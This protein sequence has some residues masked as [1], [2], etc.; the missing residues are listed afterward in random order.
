MSQAGFVEHIGDSAADIHQNQANSAPNRSVRAHARAEAVDA[1]IDVEL[2]SNGSADDQ[3][4]GGAAGGGR[5]A[6]QVKL[7]LAHGFNGGGN[8][9]HV[10]RQAASHDSID[11]NFLGSDDAVARRDRAQDVGRKVTGILQKFVDAFRRGRYDGQP[12]GPALAIEK[13]Y[14]VGRVKLKA[15]RGQ[16][17]LSFPLRLNRGSRNIHWLLLLSL[18]TTV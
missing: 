8:H 18:S 9:R 6:M 3:Q 11:G 12:I 5:D 16:G 1:A 7:I 10:V 2:L 15:P 14:R 4:G 13:L 17:P